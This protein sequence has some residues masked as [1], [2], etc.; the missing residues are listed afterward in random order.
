M[1]GL[2]ASMSSSRTRSFQMRVP[3]SKGQSKL[4]CSHGTNCGSVISS[5]SRGVQPYPFYHPSQVS[6]CYRLMPQLSHAQGSGRRHLDTTCVVSTQ[7]QLPLSFHEQLA[8]MFMA[9]EEDPRVLTAWTT[10]ITLKG[11]PSGGSRPIALFACFTRLYGRVRR[12]LSS[13]WETQHM[14]PYHW[15]Q[16]NRSCEFAGW[17]AGVLQEAAQGQGHVSATLLLDLTKAY[18]NIPHE[19]LQRNAAEL[20]FPPSYSEPSW[21]STVDT[22]F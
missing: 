5:T 6:K 21:P 11:K 12:P 17:L 3:A 7:S 15:G 20:N 13:H 4:Q 16:A 8:R 19:L 10:I 18:E 14:Q 2:S 9:Y 1:P 22:A